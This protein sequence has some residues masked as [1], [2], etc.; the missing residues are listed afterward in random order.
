VLLAGAGTVWI[1]DFAFDET[2]ADTPVTGTE[3]Q[4]NYPDS[5]TNLGFDFLPAELY[6][7]VIEVD[8]TP[9]AWTVC[10]GQLM[11]GTDVRAGSTIN[12]SG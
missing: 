6:G 8:G 7:N 10:S 2:A 12:A 4:R 1:E 11:S 9:T 5:P 3:R